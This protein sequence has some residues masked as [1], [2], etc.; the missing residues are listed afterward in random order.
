[1]PI[2]QKQTENPVAQISAA[3]AKLRPFGLPK[4]SGCQVDHVGIG[5]FV[6]NYSFFV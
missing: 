3:A 2:S 1:M 5:A 6:E 4:P